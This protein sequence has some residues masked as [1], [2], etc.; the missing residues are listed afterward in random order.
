LEAVK[1]TFDKK[2]SKK[3]QKKFKKLSKNFQKKFKKLS[4]MNIA[5]KVN[6]LE[7][8]QKSNILKKKCQEFVRSLP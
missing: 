2:L 3:V 6:L 4:K 8:M 1:T 5:Q 7:Y